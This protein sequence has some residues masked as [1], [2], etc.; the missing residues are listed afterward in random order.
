MLHA[1][2]KQQENWSMQSPFW[3][4]VTQKMIIVKHWNWSNI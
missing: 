4:V 1:L 3:E 2:L